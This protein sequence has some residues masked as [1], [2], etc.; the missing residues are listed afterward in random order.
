MNKEETEALL[1]RYL[2][3]DCDTTEKAIV[4]SWYNLR[5]ERNTVLDSAADL[6]ITEE[7][8]WNDILIHAP[9]PKRK[10]S[11]FIYIATAAAVIFVLGIAAWFYKD[12][13]GPNSGV[14]VQ[15]QF[16]HDIAPGHNK[17]TLTLSNGKIINLSD[18]KAGVTIKADKLMYND[19]TDIL[20]SAEGMK[21]LAANT[22]R[23]GQ[24]Q[25]VLPDGSKVWLNA[26][27]NLKF[28]STFSGLAHRK[29]E[30]NGEAYFEI[31]K[32]K[33]HPFI[34]ASKG[35]EVEVLGTHFNINSYPDQGDTRTTLLEGSVKVTV[36]SQGQQSKVTLKPDQ[37]AVVTDNL[38]LAVKDVD[39]AEVASWKNGKFI[40][41]SEPLGSIMKQAERWY[42]V[43][44]VF[45]DDVKDLK[46]T[47][48][49]SR[50]ENISSLLKILESTGEVSF[51]IEGNQIL[52]KKR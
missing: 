40:F 49:I 26:A 21:W 50:Y 22:P 41:N 34:V 3:D 52:I 12:Q 19:G 31:S 6:V 47:G 45:Q 13:S 10:N 38:H 11:A 4:E 5:G 29:V 37:Q 36:L 17:A 24:Y 23:G 2:E 9:R 51:K 43:G 48:A 33:K 44:I 30:L 8:I 27:S 16:N 25:V 42:N 39:A 15:H 32:D 20:K 7:L 18:A 28:P 46:L 1:K 35:Q 14:M